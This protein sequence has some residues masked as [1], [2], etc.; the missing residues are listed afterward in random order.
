MHLGVEAVKGRDQRHYRV[1]AAGCTE[2][3]GCAQATEEDLLAVEAVWQEEQDSVGPNK[4]AEERDAI[5]AEDIYSSAK[6]SNLQQDHGQPRLGRCPQVLQ[7]GE[8]TPSPESCTDNR[9]PGW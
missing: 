2:P 8:Q 6:P 3:G 4:G 5:H 7:P 1:R 9:T